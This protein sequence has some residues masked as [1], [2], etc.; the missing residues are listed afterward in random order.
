[1]VRTAARGDFSSSSLV[2]QPLGLSCGFNPAS[3]CGPP[4]GVCSRDCPRARELAWVGGGRGGGSSWGCASPRQREP[5]LVPVEAGACSWRERLQWRAPPFVHHSTMALCF[6][7]CQGFLHKH[8][9]LQTSSLLSP[10]AI[11]SQPAAVLCRG[12][13]SKP[14]VPAPTPCAHWE[15]TLGWGAQGCDTDHLCRSHS[16]LPA[17][18]WLL[19]SPPLAPEALL[20]SQLISPPLMGLPWMREPLL[21]FNSPHPWAPVQSCFLSSS[22]SLLLSFILL[23]TQGSFLSF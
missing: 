8:F 19:R 9:Q 6:Y 17:T 5:F 15:H 23:V 4:T 21:S 20:L 12:L 18:D 14:Q 11:S 3:A 1:M 10:Q 13:L 7:G 16:V 2:I 22:I